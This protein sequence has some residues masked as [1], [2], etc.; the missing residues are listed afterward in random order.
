MPRDLPLGNG[1]LLINFD[2]NYNIR[3]I[4]YPYVGKANH[5]TAAH[6]EPAYG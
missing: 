2:Q 3:D 1:R 4:Y 5:S 6:Q